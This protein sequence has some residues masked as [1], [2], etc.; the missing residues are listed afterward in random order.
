M[1]A[2]VNEHTQTEGRRRTIGG[3]LHRHRIGMIERTI[4]TRLR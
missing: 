1:K 4:E 3:A 2:R